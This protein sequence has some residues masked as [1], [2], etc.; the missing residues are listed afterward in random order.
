[1]PSS[2]QA[3]KQGAKRQG[4][5]VRCIDPPTKAIDTLHRK[6]AAVKERVNKFSAGSA[7]GLGALD[8]LN[9]FAH[10]DAIAME[11]TSRF[12]VRKRR[13]FRGIKPLAGIGS[14]E[15]G[16]ELRVGNGY[17]LLLST[18]LFLLSRRDGKPRTEW[19]FSPELRNWKSRPN[20]WTVRIAA[21]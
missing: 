11:T 20:S 12:D 5:I 2:R 3:A 6:T 1:M 18:E 19:T 7:A 14:R 4:G 8:S 21:T 15:P 17:P 10:G 16:G 9:C 13:R